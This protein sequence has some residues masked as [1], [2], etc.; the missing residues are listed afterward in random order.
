MS[1]MSQAQ[2]SENRSSRARDVRLPGEDLTIAE[3][4]RVMDVARQMRDQRE[5]AEEM[6]RRDDLRVALREKLIRTARVSGDTVTEAE[7]DAAIGQYF[8]NL[9]SYQDPAGGWKSGLAHLW[10]WRGR[11]MTAAVLLASAA[12]ATWWMFG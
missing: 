6:F 7:I 1:Q 9:H 11:V 12:A 2:A 3:T 10:V 4:L 5:T 8:E